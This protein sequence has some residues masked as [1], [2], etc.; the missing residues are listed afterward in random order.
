MGEHS[1]DP[2][3]IYTRVSRRL[4]GWLH[5]RGLPR[6][7]VEDTVHDAWGNALQARGPG[8]WL[9]PEQ[10]DLTAYLRQCCRSVICREAARAGRAMAQVLEA[11]ADEEDEAGT[12]EP[13][14]PSDDTLPRVDER[15]RRA[16]VHAAIAK[17]NP[18]QRLRMTLRCLF[19]LPSEEVGRILR[20]SANSVDQSLS[21]A[22]RRLRDLLPDLG[23]LGG[24]VAIMPATLWLPGGACVRLDT[25]SHE[26]RAVGPGT[27]LFLSLQPLDD[28]HHDDQDLRDCWILL[29]FGEAL[30]VSEPMR[31]LWT[32][33]P[34]DAGR[35]TVQVPQAIT[36]HGQ[37]REAFLFAGMYPGR[38]AD[39][40]NPPGDRGR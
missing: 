13:S 27:S 18:D 16:L 4:S 15:E 20:C 12:W 32:S 39:V 11:I 26:L 31:A 30:H 17:L 2:S 10:P 19:G 33:A 24:D 35:I 1:T 21:D 28:M 34:D 5:S 25:T 38:P 23:Y 36:A 3:A 22:R 37:L 7:R 9:M 14:R 6:E 8:L 29:H 40:R